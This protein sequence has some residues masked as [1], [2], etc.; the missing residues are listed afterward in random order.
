MVE[1]HA[2]S[3]DDYLIEGLSFKLSPGASYVTN[4]RSVSFFPSGSDTYS[5]SSGV[6]VIKI[7]VNGTDWLDPSTVKVMF[8]INNVTGNMSFLSGAHSFFRRMR[9]VC[10][11]QIVEDIDDYNRVCE[12][13]NVLQSSS[14]RQ[15]DEIEGIAR[16]DGATVDEVLAQGG[17]EKNWDEDLFGVAKSN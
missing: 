6:K 7:K 9:V 16:W 3:V 5:P 15:N 4:R 1:S 11:G 17:V 10:N 14:V 12:M 8:T 2:N 13:F